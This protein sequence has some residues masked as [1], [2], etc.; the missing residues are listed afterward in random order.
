MSEEQA[1]YIQDY[2]ATLMIEY[3]SPYPNSNE[4]S[5]PQ[6]RP[7]ISRFHP[8]IRVVMRVKLIDW[9]LHCTK[10]T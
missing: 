9:V 5:R 3:L 1:N 8:D 6:C 10:V 4:Y 7:C 2:S